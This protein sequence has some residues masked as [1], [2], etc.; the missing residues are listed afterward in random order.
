MIDVEELSKSQDAIQRAAHV[1]ESYL[2]S[3]EFTYTTDGSTL[4]LMQRIEIERAGDPI[5]SFLLENKRGHC[6]FFAAAMVAMCNTVQIPARIVT[7]YY[8]ER[9]DEVSKSYI[10]L[11]R[12]AHA[13]VEVETQP[14]AW[15][16]FDPTPP[17]EGAPTKQWN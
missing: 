1:F 4:S 2:R 16:P 7:G 5:A 9:W 14:L 6:E 3:N 12:D 10:V 17:S 8:A 15:L 11:D 13:W